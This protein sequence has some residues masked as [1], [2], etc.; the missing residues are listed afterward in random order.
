MSTFFNLEL[1]TAEAYT[2]K[3]FITLHTRHLRNQILLSTDDRTIAFIADRI[4]DVTPGQQTFPS[5]QTALTPQQELFHLC[6]DIILTAPT[7]KIKKDTYHLSTAYK[8]LDSEN[9]IILSI[10][11]NHGT[12]SQTKSYYE[13]RLYYSPV[14][15]SEHLIKEL[16]NQIKTLYQEVEDKQDEEAREKTLKDL[17]DN[18]QKAK[19]Y[20]YSL[21]SNS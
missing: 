11:Q 5:E 20:L 21:N 1:T 8:I 12:T 3:N 16:F 9:K 14:P 17:Q 19:Q 15:L 7:T 13:A 10:T 6:L 2:L 18:M 4:P